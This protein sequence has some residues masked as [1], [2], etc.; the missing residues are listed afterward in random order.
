M[1]SPS[2]VVLRED[3]RLQRDRRCEDPL[4]KS[5]LITAV[6][7]HERTAGGIPELDES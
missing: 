5:T 1:I 6:C 2:S 4:E 7:Q 3:V